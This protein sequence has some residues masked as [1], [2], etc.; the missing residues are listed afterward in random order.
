M[1]RRKVDTMNVTE[2]IDQST[3]RNFP[4]VAA[5]QPKRGLGF[6]SCVA[7]R[8]ESRKEGVVSRHILDRAAIWQGKGIHV[9][10]ELPHD[11]EAELL[12]VLSAAQ[13]CNADLMLLPPD[14]YSGDH[15]WLGYCHRVMQYMKHFLST[16]DH[17]IKIHPLS[18]HL[19]H[20]YG[21]MVS[22]TTPQSARSPY[23]MEKFIEVVPDAWKSVLMD[24]LREIVDESHWGAV[25]FKRNNL[26]YAQRILGLLQPQLA[27]E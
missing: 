1:P 27:A 3:D 2:A 4:A 20:I 5:C 6:Q 25:T 16:N 22:D 13:N 10:L 9:V 17:R 14:K 18:D 8:Y 23:I 24:E 11:L 26:S 7:I 15:E 21:E 19:N 12:D